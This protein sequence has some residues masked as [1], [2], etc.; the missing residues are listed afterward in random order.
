MPKLALVRHDGHM[1][2]F[3]AAVTLLD[4]QWT[5]LDLDFAECMD[6]IDVRDE[7][8]AARGRV[9]VASCDSMVVI[10]GEEWFAIIRL[11]FGNPSVFVSE[12]SFSMASPFADLLAPAGEP[13]NRRYWS[14]EPTV[15]EDQG[16]AAD[17][18]VELADSG[19]DPALAV[20]EI[21]ETVGIFEHVEAQR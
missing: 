21:C 9:D 16:L 12:H 6:I 10:E 19:M 20:T 15:L 13:H 14:G 8:R 1:D 2:Y 7:I 4:D 11:R 5:G 3:V 17:R 18:L